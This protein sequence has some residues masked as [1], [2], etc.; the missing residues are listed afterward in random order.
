MSTAWHLRGESDRRRS[1]GSCYMLGVMGER[2][3]KPVSGARTATG[4]TERRMMGYRSGFYT[5]RYYTLWVVLSGSNYTGV[6]KW[7]CVVLCVCA[8]FV[9]QI[10]S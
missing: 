7:F 1:K 8:A 9:R 4:R 6:P 2:R 10:R 5:G 3:A